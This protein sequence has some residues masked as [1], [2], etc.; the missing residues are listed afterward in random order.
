MATTSLIKEFE[1]IIKSA[2]GVV[3]TVRKIN[4]QTKSDKKY[5][6]EGQLSVSNRKRLEF[7]RKSSQCV[8]PQ[9]VP[10]VPTLLNM[11]AG[12]N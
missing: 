6:R 3:K 7:L 1:D 12:K 5:A 11:S 8:L 2:K 10:N 9:D 4:I